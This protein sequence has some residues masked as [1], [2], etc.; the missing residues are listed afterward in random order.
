MATEFESLISS[1]DKINKLT[2]EEIN[3]LENFISAS[4]FECPDDEG[5][6]PQNKPCKALKK[7]LYVNPSNILMVK[8]VK[9][10]RSTPNF[11]IIF[12]M[13]LSTNYSLFMHF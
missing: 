12:S 10:L 7:N 11:L 2:D 13:K 9:L 3:E 4:K 6:T 8:K 1:I 5:Q